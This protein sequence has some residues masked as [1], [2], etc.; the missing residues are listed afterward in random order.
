MKEKIG[1][2]NYRLIIKNIVTGR[3]KCQ[4]VKDMGLQMHPTVNGVYEANINIRDAKLKDVMR[5][6]LDKWWEEKLFKEDVD[7]VD[8]LRK[9]LSDEDVGLQWLA[10]EM[11]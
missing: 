9:I 3:I 5:K 7:G 2:E 4:N 1:V 8:E 10:Y 11:K 6:M